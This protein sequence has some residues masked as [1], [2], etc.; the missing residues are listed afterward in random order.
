M[1]AVKRKLEDLAQLSDRELARVFEA[2]S[3]PD[4]EKLAGWEFR[5]FNPPLFARL[6][7]IQKFKKGFFWKEEEEGEGDRELWGYN[8]PVLQGE[9]HAPWTNTH[10]ETTPKRFG[11]YRAAPVDPDGKENKHPGTLLLDYG[12]G[13]N[14]IWDGTGFIRD[15]LVQVDPDNDDLYLG[16][17]YLAAGP[18]RFPANFFLLERLQESDFA[19]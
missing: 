1:V 2:G 11:W 13:D 18:F 17:A 4:P 19:G 10:G 15:Y 6:A 12:Q 7:G 8:V 16:K 14:P 3:L 5:G 9:L